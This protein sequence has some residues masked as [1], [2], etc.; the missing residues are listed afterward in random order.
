MCVLSRLFPLTAG[1]KAVAGNDEY[2]VPESGLHIF[3]IFLYL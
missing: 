2:V 3:G 1:A